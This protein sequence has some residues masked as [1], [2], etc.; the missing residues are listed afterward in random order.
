V[1]AT[2][3]FPFPGVAQRV[4][5]NSPLL[6]VTPQFGWIYLNLNQ[7]NSTAGANPSVDPA[8]AQSV[9]SNV[10][11][12]SGRFSLGQRSIAIENTLH[13]THNCLDTNPAPCFP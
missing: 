8:A 11:D 13:T 3:S 4:K 7:S 5:V 9:V 2:N 12:A 1:L 6:Q 10:M